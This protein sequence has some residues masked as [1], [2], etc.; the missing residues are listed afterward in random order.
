MGGRPL[1]QHAIAANSVSRT[2]WS[3]ITLQL[4]RPAR[5]T[6]KD[7]PNDDREKLPMTQSLA[8]VAR[9]M[10]APGK[11]ILAADESSGTIKKRFD[12]IKTES[13]ADSRRDYREM[14]F[15]ST[16]AMKNHIS[17]V[18]LYDETIRQNAK[19]GTP[20][21]QDHRRPRARCPA[22]R[23]T[24]A[25]SRCRSAPARSITEGLDGLARPHQGVRRPRRQVRQV[26]RRDR[27]RQEHA[28]P[29]TASTPTRRRWRATP[30]C[31]WRAAWCRSSSR[32]C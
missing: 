29:T 23:S 32:R 19:D 25:P 6:A 20:L 28:R 21:R 12:A 5:A 16:E 3:R 7:T 15:R 1:V 2:G 31:A 8:D 27:H 13:T 9:A 11:G 22:S 14:L 4:Q 10:V 24:P 30:R 18:I 26:A 17:G